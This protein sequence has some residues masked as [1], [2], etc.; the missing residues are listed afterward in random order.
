[1]FYDKVFITHIPS[2]YKL[3]L[4]NKIAEKNNIFVI[5]I[6]NKSS[7]RNKDFFNNY[8]KLNFKYYFLS[9]DNFENRLFL[10]SIY[11]LFIILRKIKF[12]TII[13]C[14]W[15]LFEFWFINIFYGK[16][17]LHLVL[18]STFIESKIDF[19]HLI[20]KKLFLY[21]IKK[22]YVCSTPHLKLLHI[23]KYSGKIIITGG[24]G[25]INREK[26][27]Y[28]HRRFIF[29]KFNLKFLYVGRISPEKNLEHILIFFSKNPNY[30]LTIVGDG[31]QYFGFKDKYN[32]KNIN[33]L[34]YINNTNLSKIYMLHDVFILPSK[35]ETWGLVIEEALFYNLVL[36][37]SKNV[38]CSNDLV[39][40]PNT[41]LIFDPVIPNSFDSSIF[42]LLKNFN[43]FVK[44]RNNTFNISL[45]DR[46]NKQINSFL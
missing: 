18:E 15:D 12:K 14:G 25:I 41:G 46:Y 7:I 17:N 8:A 44:Y 43:E 33:F 19:I 45:D 22:V 10:L 36:L 13:L 21:N 31:P 29:K 2:F 3:N 9:Y 30:Q 35:F 37:V 34:G 38:G 20:L 27:L 23:L 40:K 11:K 4:Y 28:N 42:Y 24:V 5:F 32:F 39:L 26:K 16:Y 6:S 1:M